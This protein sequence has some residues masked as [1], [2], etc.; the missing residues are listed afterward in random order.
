VARTPLKFSI[1]HDAEPCSRP[2]QVY[3]SSIKDALR[4]CRGDVCLITGGRDIPPAS[5]V[6]VRRP[7]LA[8]LSRITDDRLM[9][10]VRMEL[11]GAI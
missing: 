10:E 6:L 4:S 7:S 3:H 1:S 9:F 8:R 11:E 2:A 5:N